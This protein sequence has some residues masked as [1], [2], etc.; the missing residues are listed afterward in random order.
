LTLTTQELEVATNRRGLSSQV[1]CCIQIGYFKA[2]NIAQHYF[3]NCTL[4]TQEITKH[5]HYTQCNAI[6]QIFG[7][8][9]WSVDHEQ[10][11][12]VNQIAKHLGICKV[13]LY[14]Y[15]RYRNVAIGAYNKS[16]LYKLYLI[17][18]FYI[19]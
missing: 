12:F 3:N 14:N 7:Y 5:E 18:N 4:S 10:L 6:M 16:H 9:P 15:L 2:V 8:V 11:L 1:F 19:Y 17:Y 13:T